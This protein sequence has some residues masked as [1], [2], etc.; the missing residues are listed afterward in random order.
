MLAHLTCAKLQKLVCAHTVA[1]YF[2]VH[3]QDSKHMRYMR[4]AH[5][6]LTLGLSHYTRGVTTDKVAVGN[7]IRTTALQLIGF[8]IIV[9]M[10]IA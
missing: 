5:H 4:D 1:R 6:K 7:E 10:S 3:T 9:V 8:F 2:C